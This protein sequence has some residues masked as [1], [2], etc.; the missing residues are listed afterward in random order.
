MKKIII[1]AIGILSCAAAAPAQENALHAS[2]NDMLVLLETSTA[3]VSGERACTEADVGQMKADA[4]RILRDT[5]ALSRTGSAQEH[6]LSAG[7]A[8]ELMEKADL[9]SRRLAAGTAPDGGCNL[10]VWCLGAA[11]DTVYHGGL[12]AY[13]VSAQIMTLIF[14]DHPANMYVVL[15]LTQYTAIILFL[16][17]AAFILLPASVLVLGA[18][19]LS[20][21]CFI[22]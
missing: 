8:R 3:C 15:F 20:P 14:G 5:V 17:I 16:V 12:F 6:M 10:A 2:C 19:M 11:L 4:L 21:A 9:L 18:L 13:Y 7:R 22:L 1:L